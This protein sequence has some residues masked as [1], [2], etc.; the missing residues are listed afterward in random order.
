M[1]V[2]YYLKTNET[3]TNTETQPKEMNSCER[4]GNGEHKQGSQRHTWQGVLSPHRQ[5]SPDL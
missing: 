2:S 3:Y 4:K 5:I 1:S